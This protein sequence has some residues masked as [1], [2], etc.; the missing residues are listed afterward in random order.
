MC[1]SLVNTRFKLDLFFVEKLRSTDLSIKPS[2][3][4]RKYLIVLPLGRPLFLAFLPGLLLRPGLI[5][6][7]ALFWKGGVVFLSQL[8]EHL[9]PLLLPV[10]V[11]VADG[12]CV[13]C[14]R[15]EIWKM[16]PSQLGHLRQAEEGEAAG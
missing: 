5:L 8:S 12:L 6:D 11:L 9:L 4:P 15:G 10:L 7:E 13:D 16:F 1:S 14:R 3:S 2:V